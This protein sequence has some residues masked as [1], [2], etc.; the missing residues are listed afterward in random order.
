MSIVVVLAAPDKLL[1]K[2]TDV[3]SVLGISA[4][5]TS[6]DDVIDDLIKQASAFIT[7]FT[8]REFARETVTEKIIGKG[9]PTLLLSRTPIIAVNTVCF[10]DGFIDDEVDVQDADAGVIFRQIGFSSSTLGNSDSFNYHPTAYGVEDWHVT[11]TGG[12]VLPNWDGGAIDSDGPEILLPS[13][14]ERACIDMVKTYYR[15]M[16]VDGT[17]STYRIG[18]TQVSWNRDGSQF[19][20]QLAGLSPMASSVLMFYRRAY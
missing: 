16:S 6:K 3:K 11:Y 5:D 9:L 20:P 7:R 2:R 17:I 14:L 1:A 19:S 4:G 8:G 18:D 10:R 15:G 12:Y 13:D